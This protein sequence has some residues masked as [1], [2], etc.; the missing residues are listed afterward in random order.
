[1][2]FA[3][4]AAGTGGHVYPGLAVAEQLV[5]SGV[6]RD[7]ILFV[8]GDRMEARV[9]PAEGFPFLQ[10]ELQGLVRSLS[11]RNL[12]L[13]G[14]VWTATRQAGREL[15]DRKV[16]AVLCMGGY[17]T[18]PVGMAARRKGVP[19]YLHE[20]NFQAGL[21]NRLVGRLANRSFVSF[22]G[23]RGLDGTVIGY[24][25][26]A[27][28]SGLDTAAC[29]PAALHRYGLAG[30]QPTIGVVGGSL[31]SP[32]INQAVTRAAA[33]W[34]GDPVQIIHLTGAGHQDRVPV[35]SDAPSV[36]RVV[37]GFEDRMDLFYSASDLV[38]GRAGGGLMEAATT[39]TPTVLVPGS[40]GGNHQIDNARAM[41][42]AGGA[43]IVSE[44]DL[45]TLDRV[46]MDLIAD[47]ALRARMGEAAARAA[48]PGA[49]EE[50]ARTMMGR[51]H[52]HHR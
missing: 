31:G 29:R 16:A 35:D 6:G 8:G 37:K 27:A 39:G 36:T 17:V 40:F 32:A 38:V 3:I 24:P 51:T 43:L 49:A 30:D 28:L 4:A 47:P 21:A 45:D 25:L 18:V 23:T 33:R 15:A 41:V 11:M 12:R 26:R 52:A 44:P 42:E 46:L 48:R 19:L 9:I 22:P 1:M 34:K 2:T 13:P 14:V 7:D 5:A 10:L 20:Q 50:I